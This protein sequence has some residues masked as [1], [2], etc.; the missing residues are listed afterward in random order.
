MDGRPITG[1]IKPRQI[2]LACGQDLR[3]FKVRSTLHIL[4]TIRNQERNHRAL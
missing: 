1:E 4:K 3:M 2:A